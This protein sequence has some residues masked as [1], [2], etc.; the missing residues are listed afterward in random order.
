MH[1]EDD[2]Y[3]KFFLFVEEEVVLLCD[4]NKERKAQE[5]RDAN[6]E[7][8]AHEQCHVRLP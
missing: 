2:R 7:G 4:A 6:K 5:Q 3:A 8:N 1:A